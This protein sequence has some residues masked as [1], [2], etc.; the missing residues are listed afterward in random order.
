MFITTSS[1]AVFGGDLPKSL[2]DEQMTNPQ[3]SYGTQ[4]AIM[5]LLVNDYSRKGFL[6][7]RV[8]RLPTIVIRPGK[9]NSATSSFASSIIRE[10]LQGQSAILPVEKDFTMWIASPQ[11]G[12]EMLIHSTS[13]LEEDLG[14][15]RVINVPGITV[16]VK[17]MLDSLKQVGGEECLSR[18][19]YQYDELINKVVGS[20]PRHFTTTRAKNLKF[21]VDKSFDEIINNFIEFDKQ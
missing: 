1:L 2:T 12:I 19:T 20:W 6:N 10:P 13:I 7:G 21:S 17:E 16:S 14:I 8:L 15:N 5:E 3:S 9:P 18:I 11:K 4:K